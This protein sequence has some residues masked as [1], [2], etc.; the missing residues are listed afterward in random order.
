[1]W[2]LEHNEQKKGAVLQKRYS[3]RKKI[4]CGISLDEKLM[5]HFVPKCSSVIYFDTTLPF[6]SQCCWPIFYICMNDGPQRK[7]F[8]CVVNAK[9][10]GAWEKWELNGSSGYICHICLVSLTNAQFKTTVNSETSEWELLNCKEHAFELKH[11]NKFLQLLAVVEQDLQCG[12][13]H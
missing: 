6:E 9:E 7:R 11:I 13:T 1:M 4:H 8:L 10:Q 3:Q 2:P 12:L 5:C